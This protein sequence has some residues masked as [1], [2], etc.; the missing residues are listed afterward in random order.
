MSDDTTNIGKP[1]PSV[2]AVPDGDDR[3]RLTCVDCGFIHYDNPKIIAGV[4]PTWGDKYLICKRAIEPRIGYWTVPAGFLELSESTADGAKREAWEEA[5]IDVEITG[6]IGIYEIPRISQLYVIHAG[7]MTR[8][9]HAPGP[10]CIDT[11]L[12][13]WDEIPWDELAFPSIRWALERH[14][15]G[16]PPGITQAPPRPRADKSA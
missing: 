9:N 7:R 4:V 13:S 10:D 8:E 12:V 3:E 6:L 14:R 1:G 16:L 2:W 5:R 15:E 11:R